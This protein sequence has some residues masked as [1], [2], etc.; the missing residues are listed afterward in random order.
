MVEKEG[1]EGE[2]EA[3]KAY[4]AAREES[5]HAVE[6]AIGDKVSSALTDRVRSR[7]KNLSS[8]L[9]DRVRMNFL[10]LHLMCACHFNQPPLTL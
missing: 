3:K 4:R 2:E 7:L 9:I 6:K 8:A 5:D 10:F 1:T